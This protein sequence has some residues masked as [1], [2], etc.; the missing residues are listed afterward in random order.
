MNRLIP[1]TASIHTVINS[2]IPIID[3]ALLYLMHI[4]KEI[5]T[6]YWLRFDM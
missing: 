3:V 6:F 5:L 1:F 2:I 4:N